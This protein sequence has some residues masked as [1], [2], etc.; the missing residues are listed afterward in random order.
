M[1]NTFDKAYYDRY[2]RNP[3]TRVFTPAVAR[4][5]AT[6]IANYLKYLEIPVANILD[7]G[8]GVGTVLRALGK[9]F[10]KAK[11]RGV[12]YSAYLCR[13]YGWDEGSVVDYHS[14]RSF[15]LVVCNDVLGYLD[16]RTCARAL[17]NLAELSSNVLFLGILTREDYEI[18]DQ[19]RTDAKQ[20]MRPAAWYRRR[21]S[22]RFVNVGG[23]VFVKKPLDVTIWHLDRLG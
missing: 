13:R 6:F 1:R 23:G 9:E 14:D 10:P 7:I 12:E 22:R 11:T 4:R 17:R 2:Y 20:W 16:D 19:S 3:R 15:D 5:Q 21:L 18:C 8:C